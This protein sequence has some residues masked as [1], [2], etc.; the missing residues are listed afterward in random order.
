M[1][2]SPVLYVQQHPPQ[3]GSIIWQPTSCKNTLLQLTIPIQLFIPF[4]NQ[5]A[6][7][8]QESGIKGLQK[9]EKQRQQLK[10]QTSYK[11]QK[12]IALGKSFCMSSDLFLPN[13]QDPNTKSIPLQSNRSAICY[14]S[15]ILGFIFCYCPNYSLPPS[16]RSIPVCLLISPF[17]QHCYTWIIKHQL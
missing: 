14:L 11:F 17:C 6:K 4:Q 2:Q 12:P 10:G 5:S 15:F 7:A 9:R 16:F 3:F 1:Y 13:C 8:Y